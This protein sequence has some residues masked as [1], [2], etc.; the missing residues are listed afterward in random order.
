MHAEIYFK[1]MILLVINLWNL[2]SS[3]ELFS[4]K[5]FSEVN[6]LILF[7]NFVILRISENEIFGGDIYMYSYEESMYINAS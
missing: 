3:R 4:A 7:V 5:L 2:F 1:R 6:V